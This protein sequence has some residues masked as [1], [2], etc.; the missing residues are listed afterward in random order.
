MKIEQTDKAGNAYWSVEDTPYLVLNGTDSSSTD[1][2]D[3]ILLEVD[4]APQTGSVITLEQQTITFSELPIDRTPKVGV[5]IEVRGD[6][7]NH[8]LLDGTT[9]RSFI[10]LDGTDNSGGA[11]GNTRSNFEENLIL[12][13]TDSSGS[14]EGDNILLEDSGDTDF[15]NAGDFILSNGGEVLPDKFTTSS[16]LIV[17]EHGSFSSSEANSIRK[18]YVSNSGTGYTDLPTVTV[19]ST[20]GSSAK[21]LASTSDIGAIDEV[22]ITDAG[23]SLSSSNPPDIVPRAHFIVKDV[24]GTFVAGNT[25]TT[26]EGTVKGWD[27]STNVLDLEFE[28]VV[29]ID[30]EQQS[31]S[32]NQ[33]IAF[34]EG[35][36]D[37]NTHQSGIVH[38]IL[39]DAIDVA[40]TSTD[41][42]ILD[43]TA[44]TESTLFDVNSYK[45]RLKVKVVENTLQTISVSTEAV[46]Y[47]HL[48]LPTN[49]EV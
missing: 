5:N 12:N 27:S 10:I 14:D 31:G 13:Q 9:R 21:L 8:L 28:N 1:A 33:G 17:L 16:D 30:G 46:S 36:R 4:D 40:D 42:I 43:A 41:S 3:N 20:S 23:L 49:R 18:A 35:T 19:T 45:T 2:G 48:T 24:T 34:E 11:F 15:D 44:I 38:I 6:N 32:V 22:S 26:H 37:L 7:I 47:T 29:R 25:L 39:E